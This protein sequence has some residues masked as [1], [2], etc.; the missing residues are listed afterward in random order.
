LSSEQRSEIIRDYAKSLLD[1]K[2]QII[3]ANNKDLEAA[4]K[5]SN[6]YLTTC[7]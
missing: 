2:G 7:V 1:N 6:F 5:N 4:K 3:D